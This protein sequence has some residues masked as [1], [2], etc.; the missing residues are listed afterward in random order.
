MRQ[1]VP[2]AV[3]AF[4]KHLRTVGTLVGPRNAGVALLVRDFVRPHFEGFEAERALVSVAVL[5]DLAVRFKV[6]LGDKSL[7]ADITRMVLEFVLASVG[8]LYVEKRSAFRTELAEFWANCCQC[9]YVVFV[10]LVCT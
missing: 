10:D 1:Q 7:T 2:V 4:G 3:S 8:F 9:C 5:V 6:M